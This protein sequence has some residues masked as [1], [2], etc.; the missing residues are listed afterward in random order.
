MFWSGLCRTVCSTKAL[1]VLLPLG[2]ASPVFAS[3]FVGRSVHSQCGFDTQL[4]HAKKHPKFAAKHCAQCKYYR[5]G[6]PK[7]KVE[8]KVKGMAWNQVCDFKDLRGNRYSYIAERPEA[9]GGTWGIGCLPCS[10]YSHQSCSFSS[11]SVRGM[12]MMNSSN[13]QRHAQDQMHI[14]AVEGFIADQRT[15]SVAVLLGDREKSGSVDAIVSTRGSLS[16][17]PR[18]ERWVWASQVIE[19]GDS[20]AD[21]RAF[22]QANGL[23][24][25]L[26]DGACLHDDSPE[27]CGKMV[28]C[29]SEADRRE[30]QKSMRRGI[31]FSIACDAKSSHLLLQADW[32]VDKPR[33][34]THSAVWAMLRD[35][36]TTWE[37]DRQALRDGIRF[38]CTLRRGRRPP[39]ASASYNS[40]EPCQLD[41]GLFKRVNEGL[42]IAATRGNG[43]KGIVPIAGTSLRAACHP[44]ERP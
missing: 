26:K 21:F 27:A 41:E 44:R 39:A 17:V 32:V 33:I 40:F 3:I 43:P 6:T 36:G 9:L 19:R 8:F 30:N 22:C 23:T 7:A 16:G 28:C 37:D 11:F 35:F 38:A 29:M 25:L 42:V 10:F 13:L 34:A 31:Y 2:V 24:T 12:Q 15:Q 1:F 20:Y 14:K 4:Q 5:N 18:P